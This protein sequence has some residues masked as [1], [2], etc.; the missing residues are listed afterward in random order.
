MKAKKAVGREDLQ[1]AV[2]GMPHAYREFWSQRYMRA[3]Y[4]CVGEEGIWKKGNA[5]ASYEIGRVIEVFR[6]HSLDDAT[7]HIQN[8]L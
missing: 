5:D 6:S 1:T 2:G 7:A 3:L 4:L 8:Y